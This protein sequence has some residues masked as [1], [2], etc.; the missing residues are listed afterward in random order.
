MIDFIVCDNDPVIL[1]KVKNIIQKKQ[2]ES[3]IYLFNDYDDSFLEHIFEPTTHKK[4]YILDIEAESMNGLD[5]ARLIRKTDQNSII[6]FLTG[7]QNKYNY[8][9]LKIGIRYDSVIDKC[10]NYIEELDK[11]IDK[12]SELVLKKRYIKI[13]EKNI[14]YEFLLDD[15]LYITT[16]KT[17]GKTV[18]QLSKKS[19]ELRKT[20]KKIQNE[21]TPNFEKTHRACIINKN[22]VD[23]Y[24][25]K[26]NKIY[27]D[28][29]K[30]IGLISRNYK[31]NH[32]ITKK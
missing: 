32:K 30:S 28:N 4:I 24:D 22:R 17:N 2:P 5:V 26:E 13:E 23:H 11:E 8:A 29:K 16:N 10:D 9:I 31:K 12:Y 21:L 14:S 20:L 15:I 6:M 19:Y 7:H 25:Y 18:I 27:F 3:K 1:K